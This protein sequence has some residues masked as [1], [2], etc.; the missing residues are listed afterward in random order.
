[1]GSFF[2]FFDLSLVSSRDLLSRARLIYV[3]NFEPRLVS[4]LGLEKLLS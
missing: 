1:V 3:G 4:F 2:H